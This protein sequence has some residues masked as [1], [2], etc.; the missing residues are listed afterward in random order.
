MN[1]NCTLGVMRLY[2]SN[3]DSG[4]LAPYLITLNHGMDGSDCSLSLVVQSRAVMDDY[5][6]LVVVRR[7]M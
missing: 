5:G 4:C 2:R 7:W 6:F 3:F 1:I